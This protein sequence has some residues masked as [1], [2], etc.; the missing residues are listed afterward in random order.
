M[1][2][3]RDSIEHPVGGHDDVANAVAGAML[4]AVLP[5][6]KPSTMLRLAWMDR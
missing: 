6:Q 3:W 1:R 5:K 2:S 4:L